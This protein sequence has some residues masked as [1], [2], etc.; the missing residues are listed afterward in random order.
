MH[1][2]VILIMS[3]LVFVVNGTEVMGIIGETAGLICLYPGKKPLVADEF[4]VQ[5]QID[6]YY[7]DAEPC[8]VDAYLPGEKVLQCSRFSNRT[9]LSDKLKEGNF[10]LHLFNISQNDEYTYTCNVQKKINGMFK[11][12]YQTTATLKVAANYS[13]PVLTGPV[14]SEKEV[15]FTCNSSHGYP[16]PKVY[17]I[18]RT[19]NSL[20]KTK[21]TEEPSGTFSVSSTLTIK[22]ASSDIKVGCVIENERLRE[23][24]TT[25]HW[26]LAE[27]DSVV[28]DA[29]ATSSPSL[30]PATAATVQLAV[31][32]SVVLVFLA[33]LCV[34]WWYKRKHSLQQ[35]YAAA[36][37]KITEFAMP[38]K[39][40]KPKS[41]E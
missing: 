2:I 16:E 22:V 25:P 28:A 35:K 11:H 30:P 6:A 4:R 36:L 32:G 37:P 26:L 20:V 13:K 33:I 31:V 14:E 38:F 19:D 24:L 29:P 1:C 7:M 5:W 23:N 15:T 39:M 27:P 41:T 18:N 3:L 8:N 9:R 21:L 10:T 17:W 34:W 12:V 40:L